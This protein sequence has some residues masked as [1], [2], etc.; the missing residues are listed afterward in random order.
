MSRTAPK[1]NSSSLM[2]T[3]T[4]CGA[5]A[6]GDLELVTSLVSKGADINKQSSD[7][8]MPLCT[9]AFWG[10]ADIVKLLLEN[11]VDINGTNRTTGWTALHCAAFQG[12][13]KV[14]LYLT[15][16]SPNLTLQ[17]SM[18]RTAV[19]FASAR[20]EIWPFFAVNGCQRT[21]KEDL[22]RLEIIQK[23]TD[24]SESLK[25]SSPQQRLSR[26]SR[27]GSSYVLSMSMDNDGMKETRKAL[28]ARLY[29]DVLYEEN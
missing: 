25:S 24:Q 20:D 6:A 19:D 12:H 11:N 8:F 17:D 15:Q 1:H 10:Y 9:A 27:P 23:V 13:G 3:S 16:H 22:I 2:D 21:P 28:A 26:Y 4:L 18:G 5:I 14:I 7:G 29:G